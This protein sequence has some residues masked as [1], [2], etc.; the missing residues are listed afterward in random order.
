MIDDQQGASNSEVRKFGILIAAIAGAAG[1]YLA[2]RGRNGYAVMWEIAGVFLVTGVLLPIVLRPVYRIWMRFAA[3]L[4][5]VNTRVLL[6][7][8]YLLILT[9]VGAAMRLFKKDVLGRQLNREAA[10]YWVRRDP[11]AAD[12]QS[13]EH[14]F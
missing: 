8:F 5:W 9:P 4:G 3:L 11:K 14:L 7:L 13:Y 2:W 1:A 6:T 12:K 10:S